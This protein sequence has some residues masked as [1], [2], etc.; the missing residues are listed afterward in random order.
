MSEIFMDIRAIKEE[1]PYRYPMLLVDRVQ[2]VSDT[3][4]IGL[5]NLSF[6]E[7]FFQ[8]HFPGHPIF[9]GVLQVEA[10]EQVAELAVKDKLDPE[11]KLDIYIKS[12]KQVKFRKPNNPGDRM[13]IEVELEK[14]EN[15]DAFFKAQ[16]KNNSGVT[17]Q[18]AS[19]VL[20]AREKVKPEPVPVEFN[21]YDKTE[22]IAMDIS[23]VMS[24][25]PHRYPFLLVDYI[26]AVEGSHV[27]AVKN[28]TY[29]EP[30]FRGY[31]PDYA[32]L[33][34]AIQS[35]MV[36]QAGGVYMLSRPEHKGKTPIFMSIQAAEF[37]H[38]ILPGD[39]L[40]C[41][42]DIPEGKSR[43]GRGNGFIKVGDK[44][45][46]KTEMTFAIISTEE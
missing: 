15:G 17:C 14:I 39:Q 21:E 24:L 19:M 46:S 27:I 7:Q 4:F 36:A 41:E 43:F 44:I 2:K 34:G 10:M 3:K 32:V 6:N 30:L 45:V 13:L 12:L 33:P 42:V 23:K 28:T 1:L 16:T 40:I 25:T 20:S 31:S 5:K 11:N 22:N 26:Y 18:V 35:E 38:P 29:N 8:G 9:P 37:Y